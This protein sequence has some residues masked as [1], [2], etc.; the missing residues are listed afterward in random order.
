MN[1]SVEH[2]YKIKEVIMKNEIHDKLL[3]IAAYW[4]I[5]SKYI[6]A[7]A[8]EAIVKEH[9]NHEEN[10]PRGIYDD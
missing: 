9:W 3:K 6:T 5:P 8:I 4:G 1:T 2:S 10:K 7:F